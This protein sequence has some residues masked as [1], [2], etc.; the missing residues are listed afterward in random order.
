MIIYR[1]YRLKIREPKQS[2]SMLL[3]QSTSDSMVKFLVVY[4]ITMFV[5]IVSFNQVDIIYM[6][7]P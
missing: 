3:Y 5:Q 1:L 6:N 2:A 7:L 4:H